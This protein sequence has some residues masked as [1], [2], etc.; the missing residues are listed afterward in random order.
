[1]AFSIS[2]G[3]SSYAVAMPLAYAVCKIIQAPTV[4]CHLIENPIPERCAVIIES[5]KHSFLPDF[6]NFIRAIT[7]ILPFPRAFFREW[8]LRIGRKTSSSKGGA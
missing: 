1:M 6:N 3:R 2:S 4:P 5:D 7:R 8:L